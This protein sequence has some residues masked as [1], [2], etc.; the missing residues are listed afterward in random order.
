LEVI[1]AQKNVRDAELAVINIQKEKF[2]LVI[3]LYKSLGGGR[4]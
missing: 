1:N 4:N 3:D 2:L